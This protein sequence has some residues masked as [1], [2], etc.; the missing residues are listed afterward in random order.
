MTGFCA[1]GN[2]RIS[3]LLINVCSEHS[4]FQSS[5]YNRR[6]KKES[7]IE[8]LHDSERSAN[9]FSK[10][11]R[12]QAVRTVLDQILPSGN[13]AADR[14]QAAAWIFDQGADDHVCSYITRLDR[15]HKFPITVD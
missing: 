9:L 12:S 1:V 11:G 10:S 3:Q 15:F 7:L 14:S 4:S 2:D 5:A 6:C 13:I 8:G